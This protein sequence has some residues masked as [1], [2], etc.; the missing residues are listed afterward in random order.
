MDPK[1]EKERLTGDLIAAT[2]VRGTEVYNRN[3]EHLGSI[4]DIMLHRYS[5]R[6]AYAV[7]AF[8]GFLGIGDKVHPVPWSM[9][10][11]DEDKGGYVVDI[12][13]EVLRDAPAYARDE[14]GDSDHG[15]RERVFMHYGMVP[16]WNV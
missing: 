10:D 11:Y 15:W 9:L 14:I 8:G 4:E 2:T 6:I 7:M 16:Y 3:G 12:S 13:E 5:D 1:I